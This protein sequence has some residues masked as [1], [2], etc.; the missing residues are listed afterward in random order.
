MIFSFF[1][2][3]GVYLLRRLMYSCICC[4]SSGFLSCRCFGL[5]QRL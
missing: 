1:L 4:S 3:S 5:A 2:W